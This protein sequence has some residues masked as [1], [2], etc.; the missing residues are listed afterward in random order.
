MARPKTLRPADFAVMTTTAVLLNV[1]PPGG[2]CL[3][4]EADAA[5]AGRPG[6]ST[7]A[8]VA[9]FHTFTACSSRSAALRA[10]ICGENPSRCI[11]LVASETLYETWDFRPIRVATRAAVHTWSWSQPCAAGPCSR[12]TASF[13]RQRGDS[14]HRDPLG[15]RDANASAPPS[16]HNWC[17]R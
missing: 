7:S 8:R 12:Y 10:G 14:R 17:H 6:A 4:L 13:S 5:P 2:A 11:I 1:R 15:P 16:R 9:S 3:V